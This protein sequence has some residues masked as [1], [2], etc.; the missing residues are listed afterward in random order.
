MGPSHCSLSR[1][2][3]PRTG[4]LS[5]PGASCFIS[6]SRA[7][8]AKGMHMSFLSGP[9]QHTSN[10]GALLDACPGLH[11]CAQ[12]LFL[13]LPTLWTTLGFS[14]FIKRVTLTL[15]SSKGFCKVSSKVGQRAL[16]LALLPLTLKARPPGVRFLC[17]CAA[18]ESRRSSE[19]AARCRGAGFHGPSPGLAHQPS[20]GASPSVVSL[21]APDD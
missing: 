21:W 9:I 4:G 19:V 14:P 17:H 11:A 8:D 6:L 18:V 3:S 2:F 12:A 10:P 16:I 13:P 5:E 15:P 1:A 20:E 7:Q